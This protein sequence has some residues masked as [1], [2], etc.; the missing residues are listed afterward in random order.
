MALV[1]SWKTSSAQLSLIV[2]YL[3]SHT[4]PQCSM[5]SRNTANHLCN[6]ARPRVL[7]H[8]ALGACSRD[9]A[10]HGFQNHGHRWALAAIL[11]AVQV[12]PSADVHAQAQLHGRLPQ[13]WRALHLGEAKSPQRCCLHDRHLA[14]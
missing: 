7:G 1:L 11:P 10:V 14:P 3:F 6:V 8:S 5:Q 12:K 9:M 2:G 4:N 13:S